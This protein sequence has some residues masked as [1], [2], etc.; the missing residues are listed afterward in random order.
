MATSL[1]HVQSAMK[2][3]TLEQET[4]LSFVPDI[5]NPETHSVP[6]R[7]YVVFKLVKK[8]VRRLNIDGIGDGVNQ[9][10][11]KIERIY[12]IRGAQSI[13]QSELTE[14]LRDWDKPNSYISKNRISLKFVDGICRVRTIDHLTLEFA[15]V[16]L[17]NVGKQRSG[18]GRY[19]F[20]EYDAAEE[21]KMRYEKQLGRI[22][23]IQLIST[24]EQDKMV[25]LA[26]FL[27]V[28]PYDEETSLPKTPDGYRTELLIKADTQADIVNKY[29]NS[30]EVEV[31]YLV[32]KAITDAKI[33]LGGQS[34]TVTWANGGFIGKIPSTRKSI[35]YL[36]ELAMTNSIEG[37][38]FKEQL[39]TLAT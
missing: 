21:Q 16:N 37:K 32:R 8:N 33:D 6:E 19:D 24:M 20:Y 2:G 38:K 23:T 4:L 1:K 7:Q 3:D 26:L 13:W 36:T 18:S 9:K 10:T 17:H 34:G 22:N 29:L 27:G 28:K 31:S 39:E 35:E 12:L 5:I 25:K 14:L 30:V 15:R 11:G